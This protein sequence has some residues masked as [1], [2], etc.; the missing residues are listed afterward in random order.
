MYLFT[1]FRLLVLVTPEGIWCCGELKTRDGRTFRNRFGSFVRDTGDEGGRGGGEHGGLQLG[2][3]RLRP[4]RKAEGG[5]EAPPE[6]GG[7]R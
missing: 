1:A 6:D 4:C 5:G 3:G 2:A 7:G